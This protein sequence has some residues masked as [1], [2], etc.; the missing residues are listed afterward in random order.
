MAIL[1]QLKL[2]DWHDMQPLGDLERLRLVFEYMPDE[3]LMRV[4]HRL[5]AKGRNDYPVREMCGFDGFVPPPWAYTRFLLNLFKQAPLVEAIFDKLVQQL[6][7]AL[8]DYGEHWAMGSKAI[9][10]F[11]KHKNKNDT[12]SGRTTQ[13]GRRLWEK[14]VPRRT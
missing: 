11:A 4:L 13:H 3:E 12:Y 10:S 8:P 14:R 1:P 9:A 7:E 2:F 6:R 5:R